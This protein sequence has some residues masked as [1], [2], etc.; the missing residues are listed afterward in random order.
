MRHR[1]IITFAAAQVAKSA[2]PRL[3]SP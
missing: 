2:T 3:G 1:G